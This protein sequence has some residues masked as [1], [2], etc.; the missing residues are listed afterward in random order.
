MTP[1]RKH[2]KTEQR[3]ERRRRFVLR[4]PGYEYQNRE[5]AGTPQ[6][7]L[8][9]ILSLF[10]VGVIYVMLILLVKGHFEIVP[11]RRRTNTDPV[12]SNAQIG[13]TLRRYKV[14]RG[15]WFSSVDKDTYVIP[16]L[17]S[18]RTL[19]ANL[20]RD[21]W[22]IQEILEELDETEAE[23][24]DEPAEA[25][26][27]D[28]AA[29]PG[30]RINE[31]DGYAPVVPAEKMSV[32][33]SMTPQGLCVAEG[34]LLISAY[35]HTHRHNSVIYVLDLETHKYLKEIVLQG[36]S[37]VGAI[38][39]DPT[40]RNVWVTCYD[41]ENKKAY[42]N[43][44]FLDAMEM[45]DFEEEHKA[46]P[47]TQC[48]P[49]VSQLHASFMTYSGNALYVGYFTNK[50]GRESTIQKFEMDE[51]GG[52]V[53]YANADEMTF[54]L[55]P[56][57]AMPSVIIDVSR[58]CQG[59][60]FMDGYVLISQSMGIFDS[61]IRVYKDNVEDGYLD[62]RNSKALHR[63]KLPSM[64]EQISTINDGKLYM[65]FESA[66]YAYALWPA[67]SV[68][69]VVVLNIGSVDNLIGAVEPEIW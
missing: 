66:A 27:E 65:V 5:P 15:P 12:F 20:E 16:G 49:I 33:T 34:Y 64:L 53:T 14:F 43:S 31:A 60:T 51:A 23:F 8:R 11:P 19:R 2:K 35:C 1:W 46:L 18:T 29:E 55:F 58:K 3:P 6:V 32:C 69:R 48:F 26:D 42:V 41:E 52:L 30:E 63:V 45:Y 44:F 67:V 17:K 24:F 40:H 38:A 9:V 7:V 68:D 54:S 59:M 25:E 47:F 28:A 22:S 50:R 37:H 36:R 13:R 56:S 57:I 39:Y 21:R 4:G 10:L 61:T 62:A